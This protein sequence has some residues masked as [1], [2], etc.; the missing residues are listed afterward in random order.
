MVSVY[1]SRRLDCSETL[2]SAHMTTSQSTTPLDPCPK[3]RNYK[4]RLQK[5]TKPSYAL[6]VRRE[7]RVTIEPQH[8]PQL[9]TLFYRRQAAFLV[10]SS[11]ACSPISSRTIRAFFGSR[12]S[13]L[14]PAIDIEGSMFLGNKLIVSRWSMELYVLVQSFTAHR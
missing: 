12:P 13:V 14:H 6:K 11:M 8:L 7:I 2:L 4:I 5:G 3:L 10:P 9:T 1:Q